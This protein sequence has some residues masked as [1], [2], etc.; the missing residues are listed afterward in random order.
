MLVVPIVLLGRGSLAIGTVC[1]VV[2]QVF[3][4]GIGIDR[5]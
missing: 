5:R 2:G 3:L 4:S 1:N